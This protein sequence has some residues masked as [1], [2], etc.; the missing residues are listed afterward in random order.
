MTSSVTS[1]T[2]RRLRP[3]WGSEPQTWGSVQMWSS[4]LDSKDCPRTPLQYIPP[5]QGGVGT[6]P[7]ALA[8]LL[9]GSREAVYELR[10]L[11]QAPVTQ[12][13]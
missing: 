8:L 9:T 2:E 12:H 11:P 6:H 3:Y 1:S 4:I 13:G 10:L 7:L 5:G